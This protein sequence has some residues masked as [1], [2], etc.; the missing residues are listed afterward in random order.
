MYYLG[1]RAKRPKMYSSLAGVGSRT[2]VLKDRGFD[3]R[4]RPPSLR[5]HEANSARF[6]RS[7]YKE[8]WRGKAV[9]GPSQKVDMKGFVI[10]GVWND[11]GSCN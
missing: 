11:N 7:L 2:R 9:F 6:T 10:Q 8:V 4:L 3:L 1:R 5:I